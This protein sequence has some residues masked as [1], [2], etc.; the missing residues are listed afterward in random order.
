MTESL[1]HQISY[2]VFSLNSSFKGKLARFRGQGNYDHTIIP[3]PLM[4]KLS[5]Q[6]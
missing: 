6:K 1:Q 2:S 5:Q 3:G 4:T